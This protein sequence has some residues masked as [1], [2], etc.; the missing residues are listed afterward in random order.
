[1]GIPR[2][3]YRTIHSQFNN[4]VLYNDFVIW[5]NSSSINIRMDMSIMRKWIN[6]NRRG[7]ELLIIIGLLISGEWQIALIFGILWGLDEE[8]YNGFN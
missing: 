8:E 6:K 7:I 4:T 3:N 5:N 2:K 1:M